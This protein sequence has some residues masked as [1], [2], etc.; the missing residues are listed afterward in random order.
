MEMAIGKA[1]G[2]LIVAALAVSAAQFS[3][4]HKHLY[5][6]CNGVL[7]LDNAGVRFIGPKDHSWTWRYLDI[8]QLKLET[9]DIHI[10]TYQDRK[11]RLGAD[12]SYDFAGP[13]PGAELYGLLRDHMDQRFV[14]AIEIPRNALEPAAIWTVAVKHVRSVVGSQGTLAFAP[15]AV[16]YATG[17]RNQ[18][19]VWRYEDID[20]ISSSGPFQLSI[21]TLE[22]SFDFQLKQPIT[23]ARYNQLWLHI[24]RKHGRI[25]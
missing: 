16:S 2:C 7:T 6:G 15:D 21:N 1:A 25:Q 9:H 14:A 23:E 22:K 13:I 3:V 20:T 4:R 5:G 8:R 10:L 24:E 11:M 12:E 18:A 19:R 17:S